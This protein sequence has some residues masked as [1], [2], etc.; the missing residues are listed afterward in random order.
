MSLRI[1]YHHRTQ[2][3]G[4]EGLHIRSI[5]EALRA[6]GH[7]VTVLSPPGIDPLA[8]DADVPVDKGQVRTRGMQSIWKWISRHVPGTMFEIAEIAYN[9]PASFRLNRALRSG[10][11]QVVYERY[12]F[13]LIAGA[14]ASARHGVPFVLEANEVSGIAH[15]ARAQHMTGICAAIERRLLRR[16]RGIL[17]VSSYLRDR[18]IEQGAAPDR[19]H[20]VPNAFDM[21]RVRGVK[22]DPALAARCGVADSIVIGF[23]GWF[24]EWD[25]LDLLIRVFSRLRP[26]HPQLKL[27]LV[28][29]GPVTARLKQDAARLGVESSVVF[30]GAVPRKHVLE[31]ASLLD[32]AVLPHSND[33]GS[34]VVMFEFMG[35][36]IPVVAPRLGPILDVHRDGQSAVLFDPLDEEQMQAAI[37]SL[38]D[39]AALRAVV[40]RRAQEKLVRDHS[41]AR[42]AQRILEAA[43]LEQSA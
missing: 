37:L 26:S 17:T 31:Y 32:V 23:V 9:M 43:G 1:L 20:V 5:V 30:A 19:V 33:F 24:D 21:S 13:F 11:Y 6:A 12:A 27:L 42:N 29:D 39:S 10:R 25:R 41:W 3:R 2:G 14:W 34:P 18:I 28:G 22:R 36:G 16:C 38:V 8:V 15:R 7:E 4:A 40:A 35:L